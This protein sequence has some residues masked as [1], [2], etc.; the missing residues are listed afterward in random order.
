MKHQLKEYDELDKINHRLNT[1][2]GSNE[3]VEAQPLTLANLEVLIK[4]VVS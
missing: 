4:K 3:R 2:L 1:K